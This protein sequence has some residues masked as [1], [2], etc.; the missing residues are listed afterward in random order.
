MFKIAGTERMRVDTAGNVLIGTTGIPDGTSVYGSGFV[1]ASNSRRYLNMATSSTALN[2]LIY[3][4][5]PVIR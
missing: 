1:V 4:F 3:F 2:A 5:Q